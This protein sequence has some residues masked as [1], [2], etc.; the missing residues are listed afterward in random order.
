MQRHLAAARISFVLF[1]LCGS[2][3]ALFNPVVSPTTGKILQPTLMPPGTVALEVFS[4]G[5]PP[6]NPNLAEQIWK[7][8]DEQDF[9][10]DVR[11]QLEK[12]GF[13]AGTLAGQIPP[14]LSQLLDLKGQPIAGGDVQRVNIADLATPARVT[15]QHI[16]TH[17]GQRYEIAASS[18]L[19]RMPI[20][21]NEGGEIHGLTYEQAQGIFAM[22]VTPQPDGRVEIEL[23]PEV[24]HGQAKQHYVGDQSIFRIETGRP[25]RAFDELKLTATLGP[26]AMLL[27][28]SQTARQGSLGHYFFLENNGRDDRFD[29]KLVLIRLSQTQHNDLVSP[30]PLPIK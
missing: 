10:V 25:K 1:A 9:P 30:G 20:L 11:R 14:A 12:N 17:A 8:V 6:D 22:H 15:T 19:D 21:A 2:G 13:R 4:I 24:H 3:C 28:G 7:E 23:I 26:G 16:Q 27:L 18:I 29:Q 5:I